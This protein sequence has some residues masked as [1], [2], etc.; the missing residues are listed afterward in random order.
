MVIEIY[1][2]GQIL[3]YR[4]IKKHEFLS[5]KVD[6]VSRQSPLHF[7]SVSA[8]FSHSESRGLF[9]NMS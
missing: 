9:G 6:E 1:Q 2:Q 4:F 8:W 5:R 3:N 7:F